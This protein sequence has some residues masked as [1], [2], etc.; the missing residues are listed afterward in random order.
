MTWIT[1]PFYIEVST[2]KKRTL[3]SSCPGL[4][5]AAYFLVYGLR[6]SGKKTN[7]A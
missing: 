7:A 4:G 3:T 5:C 1:I 2:F 6:R